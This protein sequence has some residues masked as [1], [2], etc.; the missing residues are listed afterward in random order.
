MRLR[1]YN[2]EICGK[3]TKN[4]WN[5]QRSEFWLEKAYKCCA[6]TS[7]R[8]VRKKDSQPSKKFSKL[9]SINEDRKN[10]IG[11]S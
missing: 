7:I 2:G 9:F 5:I 10:F 1:R 6:S 3:M 8:H 4:L 11:N